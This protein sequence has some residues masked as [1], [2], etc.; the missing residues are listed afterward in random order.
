MLLVF[1]CPKSLLSNP[2]WVIILLSC[3][4]LAIIS[5]FFGFPCPKSLLIS[6]KH[7]I[8]W[9]YFIALARTSIFLG[10]P[11]PKLLLFNHDLVIVS[12][13]LI[14]LAR[15]ST[16]LGFPCPKLLLFNRKSVIFFVLIYCFSKEFDCF[17]DF[18]VLPNSL[19]SNIKTVIVL[20][21]TLGQELQRFLFL[22]NFI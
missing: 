4:G 9:F 1:P 8:V 10:F 11:C 13:S 14:A 15:T 12:F 16:F 2:K 22:N 19:L 7:V 20:F 6:S 17:S 3:I 21:L 18:L 5:M